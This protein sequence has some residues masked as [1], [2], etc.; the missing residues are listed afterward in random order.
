MENVSIQKYIF[1]LGEGHFRVNLE[2]W[3]EGETK[4]P[5]LPWN[6]VTWAGTETLKPFLHL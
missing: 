6:A 3:S 1:A 4:L 5:S 2:Q